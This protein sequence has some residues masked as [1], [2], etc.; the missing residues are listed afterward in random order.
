MT[1]LPHMKTNTCL[2][3]LLKHYYA[4]SERWWLVEAP[5]EGNDF[6]N[7]WFPK[8]Q[9]LRYIYSKDVG[10]WE[11]EDIKIILNRLE[12][13]EN[14]ELFQSVQVKYKTVF[15]PLVNQAYTQTIQEAQREEPVGSLHG[16]PRFAYCF[17]KKEEGSPRNIYVSEDNIVVITTAPKDTNASTNCNKHLVTSFRRPNLIREEVVQKEIIKSYPL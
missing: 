1:L 8:L 14:Q 16:Y 6:Q 17:T 12:I 9:E 15:F 11:N 4:N 7:H 5:N 13:S 2:L 10:N 3:K